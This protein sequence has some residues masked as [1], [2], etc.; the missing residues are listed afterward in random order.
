MQSEAEKFGS[1]LKSLPSSERH[2]PED[3]FGCGFLQFFSLLLGLNKKMHRQCINIYILYVVHSC[4]R[5]VN[6]K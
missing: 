1:N 5:F 3:V 4:F 2:R 6:Q